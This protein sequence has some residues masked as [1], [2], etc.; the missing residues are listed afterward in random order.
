MSERIA[1]ARGW[2]FNSNNSC[3]FSWSLKKELGMV[4]QESCPNYFDDPRFYVELFEEMKK[5]GVRL[6]YTWNHDLTPVREQWYVSFPN[7]N[8]EKRGI[9]ASSDSIGEAICKAWLQW[10]GIPYE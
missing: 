5:D 2:K 3:S 9:Q 10:K 4:Y 8:V 6:E 1:K 7:W